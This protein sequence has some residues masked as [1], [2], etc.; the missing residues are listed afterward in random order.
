MI[1]LIL[2]TNGT[3]ERYEV[4]PDEALDKIRELIGAKVLD[5]V[6]LRDGRVMLVDDHGYAVVE[7]KHAD[8][9]ELRPVRMLKPPN[10][11]AT[12]LYHATCKPGTTHQIVGDAAVIRDNDLPDD[13][14]PW[15][16]AGVSR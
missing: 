14:S 8:Y 1:V 13:L 12:A 9:I 16:L 11:A 5:A 7:V 4:A 6:N 3:R 10:A 15:S 2:R